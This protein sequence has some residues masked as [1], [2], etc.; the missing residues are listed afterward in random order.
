MTAQTFA[1]LKTCGGIERPWSTGDNVNLAVGQGDLQ[2]TPLQLATAYS[3]IANGG[4]RRAA[5]PGDERRGRPR[6]RGR[7]VPHHRR[8]PRQV[9]RRPTRTTILEGLHRAASEHGGTSADVFKGFAGGK[10]TVYGKTGTVERPGQPDQSWYACY[11]PHPSRPIVVVVTVEKGGFGAETAAPA[12]RLILN[13][14]FDLG[15]D[16]FHAGQLGHTM[17]ASSTIQPASEPPRAARPARVAPA[18]GPAAA[19]GDARDRGLL[20]D[21]DQGRHRRRRRR[22]ALLLPRAP[23]DL[24]RRRARA[25]VRRLAARLLAAAR[26]QVR[27]LR[28]A[29]RLDPAR[30]RA[31]DRH[32]RLQALDRA[33]V[34]PLPAVGAGQ[35]AA[36]HRPLGL[37]RRPHAA[38]GPR[39]RRR[40]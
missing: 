31:R 39:R 15:K 11:V 36:G 38:D 26:A 17:S 24:R 21:R 29:D 22:P 3:T 9:L 4:A 30:V 10:L 2:A 37:H 12:A 16:K 6:A 8:A 27:H 7:G 20:A 1:A 34:L 40:G 28:A 35:A 13:N 33:A 14:W 5:A 19:A 25:Y 32:A 23:G 18:P